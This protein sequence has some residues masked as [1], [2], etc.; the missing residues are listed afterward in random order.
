V[1]H[2]RF[3]QF[4]F[5]IPSSHPLSKGGM[6]LFSTLSESKLVLVLV[7]FTLLAL[8]LLPGDA[9][10]GSVLNRVMKSGTLRVG[11]PYN[12]APQGFLKQSGEW[13]GFE[14]D[15][16]QEIARHLNLKLEKVKVTEKTWGPMLTKG[17]IDAALC[18][19]T[20]TRSLESEYDFS[21]PYFFD[22][23]HVLV[24]KGAFK[25]IADLKGNK[26]A[27][28][29]GSSAE[30][31][32]MSFLR[33]TGDQ[34]SEKNVQSLPDRPTCF[35]ALGREKIAGWL[36]SGMILLEY[37]SR[38]P[39]R[40]ELIPVSDSVDEV[41]VALPQ[42]DSA[43][44]DQINFALQDMATDGS[45]KKVYNQWFGADTPYAFP[46]RRSIDVWPE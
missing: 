3:Y 14:V 8:L 27:A 4:A 23:P 6:G 13:V 42:D 41:A 19:I 9:L 2:Y 11:V 1:K 34:M 38:S 33:K 17:G 15:L 29:Q 44:R 5:K 16:A 24:V 25:S 21:V 7:A 45:F 10:S 40:F 35:M 18:R 31:I 36:D 32:A 37:S 22:S 39:G 12:C 30:K 46:L 26:I 28:V 20:H 43:W